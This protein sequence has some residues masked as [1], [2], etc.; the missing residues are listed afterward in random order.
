MRT[1][2]LGSAY[3]SRSK[4]LADQRCIN[5]YMEMVETRSGKDVGAFYMTPGLDLFGTYGVGPI[6]GMTTVAG[7]MYTVSEK[8]V[9]S[10][11]ADGTG[12]F[13]GNLNT[14][15][16]P[17]SMINNGSQLAIF[18]GGDGYLVDAGVLSTI[19][20]PSAAPT[21][22]SYQDGFGLVNDAGT[23]QFYQS[24]LNDLGTWN[25]LN[26][27]SADATPGNIVALV[28]FNQAQWILK[29][30][31]TEVWVD[32]GIS[33]FAFSRIDA[34]I[35]VGCGAAFS[36]AIAGQAL[37]WLTQNPQGHAQ[38]VMTAGGKPERVSTHA[39]EREFA[40]YPTIADARGFS[41]Q[42]EG[43]VFYVL[44]FPSGNATWV[45]DV[46]ASAGARVPMWHQ[47]AA[48]ANGAFSRAWPV[49]QTFFAGAVLVGD[50]RNGNIYA[51]NLDTQTDNGTQRKWLRSWRA[52]EKPVMEPVRFS[53]LQIDMQTGIEVPPGTDPLCVLRWSDDGGHLW[54]DEQFASA[55][56]IGAAAQR[57]LF[58]RL[59]S[60]RRNSGLDR[61]FELSSTD[62]FGV[63]L[64]GAEL[65]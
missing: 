21:V 2:F 53:Q 33:G 40:S 47:R 27:S 36:P 10:I 41:Y 3:T 50:Y 9:Y 23:Q 14:A 35:E 26:F 18:D 38:V 7:L 57:V 63:G 54:S 8:T 52:L 37:L 62:A 45:F 30:D 5:L 56:P 64:I 59:G 48:F 24:D 13:I 12:S 11:S 46:T 65:S 31:I 4:N 17:V 60:T 28:T 25:A 44:N 6:R 22:G 49:A 39:V 19:A 34:S 16:G 1:P 15:D 58:R 55:G 51:Y 20:M 42:Q 29:T 61:I 43:H 32:A